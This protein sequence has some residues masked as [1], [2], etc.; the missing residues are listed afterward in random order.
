MLV[1]AALYADEV[2]KKFLET[3]Y[4][5][6][7]YYYYA[8]Y[9]RWTPDVVNSGD[10]TNRYSFVSLDS[11]GNIVGYISYMIDTTVQL[12]YDF[13]AMSFTD[14]SLTFGKDLMTC[15]QQM[16]EVWGIQTL[17][18]CVV[19]GNPAES[20]YDQLVKH[21]GG[22]IVGLQ[23]NRVRGLDGKLHDNKIYELTAKQYREAKH[24]GTH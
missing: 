16:F 3:W 9:R 14:S 12:A 11:K 8:T 19:V 23:S 7:Y 1:N 10:G 6:K 20:K 24:H 5:P 22:R 2:Q 21:I 18:W 15:I 13:G 17:E 4:D